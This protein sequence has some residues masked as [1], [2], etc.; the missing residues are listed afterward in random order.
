ME[1]Y[2]RY[3]RWLKRIAIFLILY[4]IVGYLFIGVPPSEALLHPGATLDD[5]RGLFVYL[6]FIMSFAVIQFV[7]IF[8]FM[9]RGNDYVIYPGEYDTT[10]DDVK[11]QP[12]A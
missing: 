2:R 6:I 8:W 3:G 4:V 1:R 11:G 10:F 9:A 12:A 5:Y 7:A